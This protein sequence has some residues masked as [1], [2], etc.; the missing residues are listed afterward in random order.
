MSKRGTR[1]TRCDII[2]TFFQIP[3][4]CQRMKRIK[5]TV[6][7][8]QLRTRLLLA[9]VTFL[10][11]YIMAYYPLHRT[12]TGP[13]STHFEDAKFLTSAATPPLTNNNTNAQQLLSCSE[14]DDSRQNFSSSLCSCESDNRGFNQNVIAFS[15]YGNFSDPRHYERYVNPMKSILETI[16]QVYPGKLFQLLPPFHI[17]IEYLINKMGHWKVGSFASTRHSKTA[18]DWEMQN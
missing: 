7:S 5:R 18:T 15:L 3:I 11:C 17:T 9:I 12:S 13:E 1:F 2:C 4:V 10:S 14:A 6:I 8:N 16:N